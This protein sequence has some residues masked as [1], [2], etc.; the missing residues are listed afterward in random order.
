MPFSYTNLPEL[1]EKSRANQRAFRGG[2]YPYKHWNYLHLITK[3][4]K[5]LKILELGTGIGFT[6]IAMKTAS[7]I[8]E[9]DTIDMNERNL[10]I[11]RQ[12]AAEYGCQINFIHNN[13]KEGLQFL[14]KDSYDLV[15]F[16]GFEA[17]L[18][19]FT[20]F[21]NYLKMGGLMVCANIWNEPNGVSGC[22][23]QMQKPELYTSFFYFE[24]TA[25]AVRI[26]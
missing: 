21:E 6:A 19:D 4:A 7:P 8:S 2:A 3:I 5:P 24:D 11:A 23:L 10:A 1:F 12:N 9:V 15:F 20:M 26:G 13:F 17:N 16:D 14:E 18:S 22:W 25:T